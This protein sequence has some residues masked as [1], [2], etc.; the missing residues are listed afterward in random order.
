[1]LVDSLF[2]W[3]ANAMKVILVR[4]AEAV[5]QG[6][7]GVLTDF[8]RQL[9]DLGREQAA[10][11]AESLRAHSIAFATVL[12]SPL[13]RALQTAEPLVPLMPG[14]VKEPVI[15]DYLSPE[16]FRRKKLSHYVSGL[17]VEVAVLVGHNPSL[18]DYAA[19]LLGA[20]ETA[21]ELAKGAAALI[22]FADD[23][24]KAAGRLEWLITPQW[25]LGRGASDLTAQQ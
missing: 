9:T 16:G 8:N 11:L 7:D 22:T 21:V 2:D 23:V 15:C 6:K 12:T 24:E 25:Y 20:E 4:H 10:K 17:G 3:R 5:E 18:S 19:W 14:D 13:V 1:M